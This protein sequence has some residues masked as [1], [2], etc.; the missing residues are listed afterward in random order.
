MTVYVTGDV[1]GDLK[2]SALNDKGG[3]LWQ[4]VQDAVGQ[5][6]RSK[7]FIVA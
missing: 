1:G 3:I 2:L 4:Q 7:D 6:G 5:L